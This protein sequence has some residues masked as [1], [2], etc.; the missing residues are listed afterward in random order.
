MENLFRYYNEEFE[1]KLNEKKIMFLDELNN[2]RNS[3][4]IVSAWQ[5]KLDIRFVEIQKSLQMFNL[6]RFEIQVNEEYEK[7]KLLSEAEAFHIVQKEKLVDQNNIDLLIEYKVINRLYEF[8]EKN[9]VIHVDSEVGFDPIWVGENETEFV[10]LIHGLI[11]IG[12]IRVVKSK[13]KW[14]AVEE[15][16][17]LFGMRLSKNAMSNF[18]KS[19]RVRNNDYVPKIFADL[20]ENF[21]Q[22]M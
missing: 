20:L 5:D 18:S 17:K 3:N 16:A 15:V 19:Y 2:A 7:N 6:D 13:G 11:E 21:K 22:K 12:K 10:Q 9:R 8:V 1:K 14:K 4:L